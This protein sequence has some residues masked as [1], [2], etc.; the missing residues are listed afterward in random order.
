MELDLWSAG[1]A[2]GSRWEI[3]VEAVS[4]VRVEPDHYG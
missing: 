1:L 2:V 4:P 3:E